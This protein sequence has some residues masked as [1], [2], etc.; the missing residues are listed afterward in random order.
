MTLVRRNISTPTKTPAYISGA[1]VL[2]YIHHRDSDPAPAVAG[3]WRA[4]GN[5]ERAA[6]MRERSS[7]F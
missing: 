1:G 2:H 4:W 6:W 5:Q 7:N 3:L